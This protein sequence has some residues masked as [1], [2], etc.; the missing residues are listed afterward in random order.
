MPTE[1]KKVSQERSPRST[2]IFRLIGA[3]LLILSLPARAQWSVGIGQGVGWDRIS[4]APEPMTK[5]RPLAGY[6]AEIQVEW[7]CAR[8]ISL[9]LGASY[10]KKNYE[11]ARTGTLSGEYQ[12]FRN[13]YLQMPFIA[14][15][16]L[17][18]RWRVFGGAGMYFGYW[19]SGRTKGKIAD[20][21]S[22]TDSSL[23]GGQ[24]FESYRLDGFNAAYAFNKI[25]DRRWEVGWTGDVGVQFRS[26]TKFIPFAKASYYYSLS[27]QQKAYMTDQ[28]GRYNRVVTLSLGVMYVL[29]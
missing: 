17:G 20:I 21:F 8:H 25:R 9:S 5:S 12:Q 2:G 26:G 28:S 4:R 3:L 14:H 24:T 19:T 15:F 7:V 10:N 27:D 16:F 18:E 22:V 6:L 29:P 13:G 11:V 1:A 23:T